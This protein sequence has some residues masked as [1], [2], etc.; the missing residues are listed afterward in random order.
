MS[1]AGA[2]P[3]PGGTRRGL[4]GSAARWLAVAAYCALI[5]WQSSY[6][7]PAALPAFPGGDKLLHA[8]AWALLAVLFYRAWES[9]P[10]APGPDIIWMLA[11]ASAALYG[12]VD[13]IHQGFVAAR[14]AEALDVL[15]DAAGS[16][17]G[18]GLYRRHGP[19]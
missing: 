16:L 5:W 2:P 6:P 15:A 4:D 17:C 18:A 10:I 19:R 12:L 11:F 13:E 9:L 1:A 8:G 3:V 14:Q 7:S